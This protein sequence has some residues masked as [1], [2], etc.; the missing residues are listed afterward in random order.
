MLVLGRKQGGDASA[1]RE[2]SDD[3]QM[4]AVM[5]ESAPHTQPGELDVVEK[6][7]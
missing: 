1:P 3:L 7:G 2:P 4:Q 6:V 5:L